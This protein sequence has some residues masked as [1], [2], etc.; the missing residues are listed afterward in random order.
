MA[1]RRWTRT[2]GQAVDQGWMREIA[3]HESHVIRSSMKRCSGNQT[4]TRSR[5]HYHIIITIKKGPTIPGLNG[6]GML[7]S[8]CV[9]DTGKV[10]VS[11]V[12]DE[13][14]SF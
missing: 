13:G 3:A 8:V 9:P 6:E 11:D 10:G 14:F 7:L 1:T 5:T 2:Q 4:T 12:V